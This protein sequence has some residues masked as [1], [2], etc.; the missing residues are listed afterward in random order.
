MKSPVAGLYVITDAR[1][2]RPVSLEIAVAEAIAGG[3]RVVQYRDKSDDQATRRLEALALAAL[4]REHGVTFIVND[5][6]ALAAAV[7]ADGVHI[8]RDDAAIVQARE[9]LGEDALIGVSC[10]NDLN[11][12]RTAAAVG[13]DYLAFGSV[14]PSATK[15][16]AVKAPLSLF[17]EARAMTDLPL[18]AIGGINADN[19]PAVTAAGADALAV[20]DAV[21]AAADIRQAAAAIA[22]HCPE[23]RQT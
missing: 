13:A 19:A 2:P 23:N 6:V 4:C 17:A 22:V 1:W 8:G 10:Y 20:V 9:V 14:Y 16:Q 7:H 21:F 3:A 12:A 18:V 11:R 5:D 15:P